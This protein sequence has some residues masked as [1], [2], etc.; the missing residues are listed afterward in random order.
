MAKRGRP[1]K[2][3]EANVAALL[4]LVR[5]KPDGT[6][7]E[8]VKAFSERTG[9][10]AHQATLNKALR[11]AGMVR[12]KPK[13]KVNSRSSGGAKR[14]EY[15][16]AHR[17]VAQEQRYPGSLTDAEWLLIKNLFDN[18]NQRGKPPEHG[19]REMLDA[20]C[21]VVRT[22][23][24]WR[25][26]PQ[27]FPHWDNVYKTFRRWS[28]Q[29]KFEQMHDRLRGQWRE[30]QGHDEQPGAAV[31]D[32]QSTRHSPQSGEHGYDA[33]EKVKRRKRTLVVDTCG[34]LLAVTVASAGLQDHDA[35]TRAL[36]QAVT[37][38]N[39]IAK[40]HVDSADAGGWQQAMSAQRSINV[41]VVRSPA[42]RNVER[43]QP[44]DQAEIFV[45]ETHLGGFIPLAKRWV[46]ECTHSWNE[47][48]GR[49]VMHHDRLNEVSE[50]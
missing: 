10:Q 39:G 9:V 30:R 14:Y 29:G 15:T 27:E 48:A 6:W 28:K 5:D 49:L 1:E 24:S 26:L 11:A 33:G 36:Q 23:C 31:L 4:A 37:K 47:R 16:Q 3:D 43:W 7:A 45:V 40:N 41:S 35:A 34:L 13:L 32:A 2:L 42:N 38:Y 12:G 50:A 8:L 21:Y 19:R 18:K 25:M 20:C 46:V 17:K 44:T 22:G